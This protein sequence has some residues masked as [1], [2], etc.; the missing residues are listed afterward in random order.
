[1]APVGPVGQSG[2]GDAVCSKVTRFE[3]KLVDIRMSVSGRQILVYSPA[4]LPPAGGQ[5]PGRDLA[6][7]LPMS[8]SIGEPVTCGSIARARGDVRIPPL[9]TTLEQRHLQ[10]L[11]ARKVR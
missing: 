8:G 10:V 7:T 2:D 3:C 6:R 11:P 4:V 9:A 5:R 1:M